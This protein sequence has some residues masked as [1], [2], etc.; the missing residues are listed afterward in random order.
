MTVELAD[1]KTSLRIDSSADDILLKGYQSA[2]ENYVKNAIG[3]DEDDFYNQDTVTPLFDVAV[4]A[5]AS[6]YYT[7]RTSLSLVQ[8]FPVDLATDSIIA[9]L[10]GVYAQYIADKGA[11]DGD[12]ST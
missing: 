8:A 5:L 2:A 6:G 9:Q 1:L 4:I 12:K 7:F 11:F 10:R 3:T